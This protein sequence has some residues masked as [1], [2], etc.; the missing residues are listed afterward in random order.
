MS[1]RR[2]AIL[3]V[4]T[5]PLA[6]PG[7]GD[8]GG[9]N[10]YVRAL[11][12]ALAHAGVECDVFTRRER[13]DAPDGRRSV[14]AGF[15]VVH[16]DAGPSGAGAAARPDRRSSIRSSTRRSPGCAT[17]GG[18]YDVLHA[19]YW[20]SG[21]V[22]HRLKHELDRPLVATFHTLA[23]VKAEAGFDDEP[24]HRVRARARDRRLRRPDAR[25]DGRGAGAARGALRRRAVAHR[26]RAA[27]RRPLGVPS[28][29]RPGAPREPR[30]ASTTGRVLLFVGRIQPLKGVDLAIARARRARRSRQRC[31]SSSAARAARRPGGAGASARAASTSSG[32][33]DQVR[34]VPPAA[35]R[36]A[37]RLLPRRRRVRR[38]VAQRVVRSGRARSGRVRN[39]GRRGRGRRSA[40]ARRRRRHRLPRRRPRPRRL[41][42]AARR[43]ARRSRARDATMGERGGRR[44]RAVTRGASP[45]RGCA[46]STATSSRASPCSAADRQLTPARRAARSGAPAAPRRCSPSTSRAGRGA[47]RGCRPSSTTRRSRAGTCASVATGAT[48]RRSTSTC[49][50]ARCATSCTSCP[51]RRATTSSSTGSCSAQPRD[52]TAPA[53]RSGPTATSTSSAASLLEHLDADELDRVLGELYALT[54]RWFSAALTVFR[55]AAWFVTTCHDVRLC[56]IV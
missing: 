34:F 38:A 31:S 19:N 35:P 33:R 46:G 30:S 22:G 36:R 28:G 11:A 2:V 49:T 47:S 54:E 15:R 9:M 42:R 25:V 26:D 13:S 23:R 5:S 16:V 43:A 51:T 4:H 29:R 24:E 12:A 48:R 17:R 41:R 39:A 37:R 20:V 44:A 7:T 55:R 3:S 14:E 27:G 10:V 32:S 8:G 18:D 50:S 56:E 21:A 1:V 6:Q 53:S 52:S 40:L 45:R